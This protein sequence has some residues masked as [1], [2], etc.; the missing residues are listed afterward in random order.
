MSKNARNFLIVC[1]VLICSV[2]LLGLVGASAYLVGRNSALAELEVVPVDEV[3]ISTETI[4]SIVA[5][6]TAQSESGEKNISEGATDFS[7][8]EPPT[9]TNEP[10]RPVATEPSEVGGESINVESLNFDIFREVWE[11]V[12]RDFDG[13]LPSGDQVIYSAISGSLDTL[14]D[15]FTGFY[16][17]EIAERMR[18][19][20]DGSFEGI[21]AYVDISD[22]GFLLIIRPIEGQ[23]AELAGLKA[24]DLISH[25]DGQ[26]IIGLSLGEMIA[27]V[28]GPRGSEVTLT[29]IREGIEEPFEVT[30][31]RKLIEIPLVEA[32]MLDDD[33]GYLRLTGF[34]GNA[35]QQVEE[36]L[37]DLL[38]TDP[39]G[40]IFDLR[41][42]PGGLLSQSVEVADL[43]LDDGIVLYQ[44]DSQN[45]EEIFRSDDGEVGE[46]IPLVVLVNTGSASASEI[47]AGAIQDRARGTLIG[48]TTFGKGSVQQT[49]RLSDGSELRVTIARWYT[50]DNKTIDHE[51]VAPDIEVETPES[52]GGEEDTQLQEAIRF[53]V[54]LG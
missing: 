1:G 15:Q 53:L 3:P 18:E 45:I 52:F 19:Q 39:K 31:V 17:P 44:R 11:I 9:N 49:H 47:V 22:D 35:A 25:V 6:E 30:I 40:L 54:E 16:S 7:T 13:N 27:N 50:P 37:E 46:K 36:A 32:E 12:N 14:D 23:P 8:E 5:T 28:K 4:D 42:N 41:D 48:E 2:L 26:S 51:G 38:A 20:L 10:L 24:G 43:F 29:I 33:V 21:G 34:S